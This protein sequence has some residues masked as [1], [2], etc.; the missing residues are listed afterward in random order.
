MSRSP[1]LAVVPESMYVCMHACIGGL[2]GIPCIAARY[3]AIYTLALEQLYD[4]QS[5]FQD[6]EGLE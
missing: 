1:N 5:N 6:V 2:N 3:P 4:R